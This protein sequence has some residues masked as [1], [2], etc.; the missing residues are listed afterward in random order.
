MTMRL[1]M[2][3]GRGQLRS[4]QG[5]VVRPEISGRITQLNFK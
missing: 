4:R 3:P 1:T 2:R 5:V